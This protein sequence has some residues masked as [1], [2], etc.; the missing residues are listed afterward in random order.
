[1]LGFSPPGIWPKQGEEQN[2]ASLGNNLTPTDGEKQKHGEEEVKKIF[3][4]FKG[5]KRSEQVW[6][7][8]RE[9]VKK[10]KTKP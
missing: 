6:N 3:C 8:F 2:L 5:R 4:L 1:M 10:K 9:E 7:P